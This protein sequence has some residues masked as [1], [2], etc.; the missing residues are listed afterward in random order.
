MNVFLTA[1]HRIGLGT[2]PVCRSAANNRVMASRGHGSPSCGH[3]ICAACVNQIMAN[4]NP[5]CP[6][7]RAT[8]AEI[9]III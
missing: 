6:I 4:G 1:R 2:C 9:I 7:C 8:I 3:L 5:T